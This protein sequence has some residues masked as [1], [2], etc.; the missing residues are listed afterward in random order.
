MLCAVVEA[1]TKAKID[2][3]LLPGASWLTY[4]DARAL[5]HFWWPTPAERDEWVRRWNAT[6]TPQ[7]WTDPTLKTPWDFDSMIESI[8]NGEYRFVGVQ[9]EGSHARLEFEPW[10]FPYG[11][12]GCLVALIEAFDLSV[13]RVDA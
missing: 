8:A 11:G 6:P 7:R 10:A 2:G 4:F 13:T 9:R 1:L 5:G 12:T 3:S